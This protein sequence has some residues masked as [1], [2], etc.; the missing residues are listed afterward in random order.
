[1]QR[2]YGRRLVWWS[3]WEPAPGH[4]TGPLYPGPGLDLGWEREGEVRDAFPVV[5]A[6]GLRSGV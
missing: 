4:L 6:S 3:L 2:A 1:M 5:L